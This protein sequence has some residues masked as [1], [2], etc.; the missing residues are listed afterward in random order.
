MCLVYFETPASNKLLTVRVESMAAFASKKIQ[1]HMGDNRLEEAFCFAMT[2]FL[3]A[4]T[5]GIFCG[6]RGLSWLSSGQRDF[7]VDSIEYTVDLLF[8]HF[9][10]LASW[11]HF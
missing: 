2:Q 4:A 1:M 5:H 10:F 3:Q 6:K 8:L 9:F 11:L 7:E